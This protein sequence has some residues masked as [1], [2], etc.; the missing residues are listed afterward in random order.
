M[1]RTEDQR[2]ILAL[3]GASLAIAGLVLVTLVLPAEYDIDP[4]GTGAMLGLTGLAGEETARMVTPSDAPVASD[5]A[6]FTLQPWESVEYK[7]ALDGNAGLVY[8]W[9]ATAPVVYEFH[10]EPRDGPEG[11]AETWTEGEAANGG[12][13]ALL[14]FAGRHGW[15]FEN[16]S[17]EPVTIT[18][19][20]SGQFTA[21]YTYRDGFVSES[22][23][24]TVNR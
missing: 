9:R 21:M 20:A 14:P 18:L 8:D 17:F 2:S 19:T 1:S 23:P 22:T 4:L 12:G 13:T 5:R 3:T 16:R 11:F 24:A 10:G 7:Y 15:F 6:T